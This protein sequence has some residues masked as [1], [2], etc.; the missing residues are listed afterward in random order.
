MTDDPT[1][2]DPS[3]H[4]AAI[5]QALN[6]VAD[7]PDAAWRTP[8]LSTIALDGS[9]DARTVVLRSADAAARELRLFADARSPKVEQLSANGRAAVT[10]WDPKTQIQL[11]VAG[12]CVRLYDDEV[13]RAAWKHVPESNRINYCTALSPGSSIESPAADHLASDGVDNFAVLAFI[14]QSF[15][16]LWLD[17][18]S[19]K[20]CRFDLSFPNAERTWLVP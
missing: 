5:W 17:R 18:T 13:I 11:R 20:R 8:T 19:H 1:L 2:A 15:D 9:P 3:R 10:F 7:T 16:W 4:L 6:A 14:A 12:E